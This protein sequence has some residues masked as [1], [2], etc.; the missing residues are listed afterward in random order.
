MLTSASEIP[1]LLIDPGR[2]GILRLEME[3]LPPRM[4]WMQFFSCKTIS[5]L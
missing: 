4:L 1:H 3:F 2:K 5:R